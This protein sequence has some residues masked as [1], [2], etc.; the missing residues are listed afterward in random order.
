MVKI[1]TKTKKVLDM[2]GDDFEEFCNTKQDCNGY[3]RKDCPFYNRLIC[4]FLYKGLRNVQELNEHLK[5]V[6]NKTFNQLIGELNEFKD[7]KVSWLK[8]IE[9]EEK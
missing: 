9:V 4:Q 6:H 8:E 2:T 3:C 1:I 7:K 5:Y